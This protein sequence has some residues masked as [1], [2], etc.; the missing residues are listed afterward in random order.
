MMLRA[1]P[2][3]V[4]C[5]V[6]TS[7]GPAVRALRLSS[8]SKRLGA[9]TNASAGA[10][11][12]EEVVGKRLANRT[13]ARCAPL[14]FGDK[15]FLRSFATGTDLG[16]GETRLVDKQ[17]RSVGDIP[18]LGAV[19]RCPR[20][21]TEAAAA[22][23]ALW[24]QAL[25]VEPADGELD[26][27]SPGGPGGKRRGEVVRYLEPV[28]LVTPKGLVL[29]K[30]TLGKGTDPVGA[31]PRG[32]APARD[33]ARLRFIRR[34]AQLDTRSDDVAVKEFWRNPLNHK[35][36]EGWERVSEEQA[37]L[38]RSAGEESMPVTLGTELRL[39]W[40]RHGLYLS[41]TAAAPKDAV[42]L[43]HHITYGGISEFSFGLASAQQGEAAC[44]DSELPAWRIQG[45]CEGRCALLRSFMGT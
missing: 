29:E 3:V 40:I 18:V 37:R 24:P 11:W 10:T 1:G 7:L 12:C 9:A 14:R 5:V 45:D 39:Q 8:H 42:H 25:V 13:G 31:R 38:R 6:A 4:L 23:A 33:E 28:R 19:P 35:C 27:A 21:A 44:E 34:D 36:C 32:S 16:L 17:G 41:T 43:A 2:L 15:V 26:D 20:E 22:H 30:V